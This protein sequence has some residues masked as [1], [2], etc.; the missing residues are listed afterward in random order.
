MTDNHPIAQPPELTKRLIEIFGLHNLALI[1]EAYTIIQARNG[2]GEIQLVI[3]DGK[4]KG[5]EV[6]N[7]LR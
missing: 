6:K 2:H 7:K 4:C 5:V 3:Y 1:L